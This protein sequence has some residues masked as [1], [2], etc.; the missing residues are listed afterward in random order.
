LPEQLLSRAGDV[1]AA[2]GV[3][4]THPAGCQMHEDNIM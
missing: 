2:S 1:G 4:G 3:D